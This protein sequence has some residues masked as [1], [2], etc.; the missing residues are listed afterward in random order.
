MN[1]TNI[2]APITAQ[3]EVSN[4]R[5][6]GSDDRKA[7]QSSAVELGAPCP[8]PRHVPALHRHRLVRRQHAV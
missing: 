5:S 8:V 1:V 4:H 2:Y 7:Q 6:E 3:I